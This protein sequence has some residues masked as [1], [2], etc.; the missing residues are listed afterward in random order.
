MDVETSI[1]TL[2]TPF[3]KSP[4][5]SS[6]PTKLVP[7][8]LSTNPAINLNGARARSTNPLIIDLTPSPISVRSPL[9]IP[10]SIWKNPFTY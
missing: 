7:K 8:I 6:T 10:L 2:Y 9:N 5:Q 3:H 4:T 1:I